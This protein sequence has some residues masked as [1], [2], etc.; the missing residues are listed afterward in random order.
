MATA[1][2]S[3]NN[4][5]GTNLYYYVVGPGFTLQP[6]QS[7]TLSRGLNTVAIEAAPQMRIY[8]SS[9][10]GLFASPGQEPIGWNTT[11]P[12]SFYEYTIDGSG[13]SA[14]MS[15]IDDWAYPIQANIKDSKGKIH[16]FGFLN[17]ADLTG[18]VLGGA[19]IPLVALPAAGLTWAYLFLVA[20]KLASLL[21]QLL[22]RR[23]V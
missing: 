13:F 16:N 2:L 1:S 15:Y 10:S 17:A 5:S 9:S 8:V 3:I 19:L 6:G 14:D 23:R 4:Q 22:P 11:A 18:G 7:N 20:L 21:L 12:F